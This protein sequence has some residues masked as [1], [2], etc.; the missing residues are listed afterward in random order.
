MAPNADTES[1]LDAHRST[2][3]DRG[4]LDSAGKADT[5]GVTE[6]G[7]PAVRHEVVDA[8]DLV[9]PRSRKRA[10]SDTEHAR[11]PP[12]PGREGTTVHSI[13]GDTHRE[14][15][16]DQEQSERFVLDEAHIGDIRG[17]LGTIRTHD[18]PIR[19]SWA[20]K[21]L[22]LLAI[23]GPGLIVM[24]GDNDAGGVATYAQAGQNYGTGLLWVLLIL[25]PVLMI[26]QEMVVRLGAV[27]GVGHGRLIKERFGKAWAIFS[28]IDLLV[29]NFLTIVTEFIGVSMAL[30]Y[31]GISPYISVPLA[32]AA[33]IGVTIS[34]SF[35][36]WE[37][38]MYILIFASLLIYPL[39]LMAHPSP[40]PILQ[41]TFIPA[42]PGGV[43]NTLVM[44]VIAIIGTTIAPWQL[45]FQQSNVVD[46][47]IT[48]R[49]V[50]YE[51]ADTFIGSGLTNVAAGAIMVVTA[52]AFLHTSFHGQFVSALGVER[53]LG[54][55]LGHAA[56]VMF[57]IVLLDASIIGAAAVTLST[58]YATAD[59]FGF[60]HSLHR[61]WK[62]A[63]GFYG[64]YALLVA[65]AASI[66]LIP[67][68]PLGLM[69]MS[70]Q[71]LAG[72]LLPSAIVFLLILC[73]D[74][75]VLGPWVNPTWLNVAAGIIVGILVDLSIVLTVTVVFPGL[76]AISVFAVTTSLMTV[77]SV[78]LGIWLAFRGHTGR[79]DQVGTGTRHSKG[80]GK[81]TS[82]RRAT[83]EERENWSMPSLALLEKPTW[84]PIRKI[85]M[86]TLRAYIVLAVIMLLVRTIQLGLGH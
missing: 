23:M 34:G 17:A 27:T 53:A 22:A 13:T 42:M 46:K 7:S 55:V 47:R 72:M 50:N 48:P 86:I 14:A 20:R 69:T 78:G 8:H 43:S 82:T 57:S 26:S 65:L 15:S 5:A 62:D 61:S 40:G 30:S 45:F 3:A 24:V 2:S 66:V 41:G 37:S 71:V 18:Q 36:R 76:N 9:R 28:I 77:V 16:K 68:A 80:A 33:L 84:S 39:A 1:P 58:S 21:L 51:R 83:K 63:K 74:Q 11:N 19:R 44:F 10:A 49:W 85:G 54:T 4:H 6:H 38:A 56:G 64:S 59:L 31:L 29:L 60:R 25:V 81:D 32:A 67:H 75:A 79:E 12:G 35:R 52:F 73:N 70:V